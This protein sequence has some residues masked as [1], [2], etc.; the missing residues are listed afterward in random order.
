M[1]ETD[2][3][4]GI[5]LKLA[6]KSAGYKTAIEFSSAFSIPKTTYSQHEQGSRSL[7]ADLIM[8]YSKMLCF[9]PG[10]L[11]TGEGHPCP[12]DINKKLRKQ[13]IAEEIFKLQEKNILPS[14]A[15]HKIFPDDNAALVNMELFIEI[16]CKAF[17]AFLSK[18]ISIETQELI[19]FCIRI[20]NDIDIISIS[21]EEKRK[22]IE[23]SIN[24]MLMGSKISLKKAN[25]L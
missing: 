19:N 5:R 22:I 11:L 10:W 23:I 24:S 3:N 18:K 1:S 9:D 17:D 8:S 14:F 13:F 6:R 21:L 12:L 4:V 20:Y 2:K 16:L 25:F 15:H 7:T